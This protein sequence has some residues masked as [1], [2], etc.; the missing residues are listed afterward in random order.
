MMSGLN[1]E[2][3]EAAPTVDFD[4]EGSFSSNNPMHGV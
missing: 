4:A 3:E 1:R 2:S